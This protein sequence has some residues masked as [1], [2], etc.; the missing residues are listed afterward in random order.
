VESSTSPPAAARG[1]GRLRSHFDDQLYRTGYFLIIGTGM[2][3]LLGVAFWALAAHSYSPHRVGLNAAAISAM[4]LVS[5]VCSLGLSSV[6]IRYLPIAGTATKRLVSV[7]YGLTALLSLLFGALVAL[8]S[9]IWSPSLSFLQSGAWLIGFTLATAANTIFTLQDSVLTGL[10]TAKW[11]PLENSLYAG[12]KLAL[13]LVLAAALPFSGPFVAW[14]APL[15]PAIIVINY[16]IYRRLIP[17]D[18][19]V[20]SLHRRTVIKMAAGNYGGNL[21]ALAGTMYLPVLVAN[22]TDPTQAAYFYVP[23]LFSLSLQLVAL[24]MMTSLTVEAAL[25]MEAMRQL[26]RRTLAHSMR[27]VAPLVLLTVVLAPY[28]LLIFGQDYSEAGTP[29]LR[30][31][32][33]GAIPNVVVSLGVSIAR[34]EHRGWAVVIS[35]GAHAVLVI[36]LSAVLLPGLGI[37]AVGISWDI[38]QTAIAL[39]MLGT[40]LR[41]LLLPRR[42]SGRPA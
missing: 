20:G 41:P 24:N 11:I 5:G 6:L 7:S 13:L 25:D 42:W 17:A 29:L 40:I 9:D 34:I 35:Q 33:I 4:S 36:A 1:L 22:L 30:W 26:A 31:L 21:F 23:W 27:L 8:T 19:S 39:V 16:L 28:G 2:T 14:N 10:R 18:K 15:L 12:G 3:S 38:S 37:E 32:A